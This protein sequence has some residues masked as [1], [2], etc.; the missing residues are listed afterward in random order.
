MKTPHTPTRKQLRE[1][2]L[3]TAALFVAIFG[4]LLPWVWEFRFPTWPWGVAAVL[5]PWALLHPASLVHVYRPWMKL[6]EAIGWFNTRVILLLL[7]FVILLPIGL[8]MRLSGH[9]PMRLR[10]EKTAASYRITRS[11]RDKHHMERPF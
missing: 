6:A 10:L 3:V 11:S 8:L 7:F 5:A 4:L 2:G 9:D 1:F